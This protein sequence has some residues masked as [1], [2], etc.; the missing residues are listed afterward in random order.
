MP[1]FKVA[2][3]KE[4]GN[5]MIIVPLESGFGMKSQTD[6]GE[7]T[8]ELQLHAQAAGLAGTVVPV[9]DAG[10]GRMGFFAPHNWQAFFKS[11]SLQWVS[12]NINK[13]L[14]W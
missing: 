13:E 9:W 3:I 7:I 11:I 2:H 10:S 14:Y 1:R 6:Q 8:G 5:N 12:V 4:Q